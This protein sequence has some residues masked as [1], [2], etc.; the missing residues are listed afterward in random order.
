MTNKADSKDKQPTYEELISGKRICP[1][2]GQII[3]DEADKRKYDIESLREHGAPD[4]KIES[5]LKHQ[6]KQ[7]TDF[8]EK[9]RE[10][11]RRILKI[12]KLKKESVIDELTGLNNL[13]GYSKT[14]NTFFKLAVREAKQNEENGEPKKPVKLS[15][16]MMDIDKFKS[17]NDIFGHTPGDEILKKVAEITKQTIRDVDYPARVGGEEFAIIFPQTDNDAIIGAERLRKE[18]KKELKPMLDTFLDELIEE[19]GM[20]AIY[21]P[22]KDLGLLK[23]STIDTNKSFEDL[24]TDEQNELYEIVKENLFGTV[25]IGV[26]SY[27]KNDTPATIKKRADT[28]MYTAKQEGRDRVVSDNQII[29]DGNKENDVIES[30]KVDR[31]VVGIETM[32][33]KMQKEMGKVKK[34]L[35]A[36][37]AKRKI[38]LKKLLEELG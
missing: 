38:I 12:E 6:E 11:Y 28:A 8:I 26:A 19:K 2:I 14:I 15:V 31:I 3:K 7:I 18:I 17:V 23:N 24:T 9:D 21:F 35:P 22:A 29:N 36:K 1:L 27:Q 33:K 10:Y 34:A 16:L 13:K 20:Q 4:E 5:L 37:K 25:S 32:S 30:R